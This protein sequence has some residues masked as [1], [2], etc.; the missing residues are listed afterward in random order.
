[1]AKKRGR[2]PRAW[3]WLV[4]DVDIVRRDRRCSVLDACGYL[5]DGYMPETLLVVVPESS[6][7][8][9]AAAGIKTGRYP[10][11]MGRWRGMEVQTLERKYYLGKKKPT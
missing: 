4:H 2:P 3:R 8:A 7:A 5:A 9:A 10:V 11:V 6:K 1:M